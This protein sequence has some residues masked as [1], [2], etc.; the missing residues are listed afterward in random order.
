MAIGDASDFANKRIAISGAS[1]AVSRASWR[2]LVKY[3]LA[4]FIS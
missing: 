2:S 4:S 1:V 3:C